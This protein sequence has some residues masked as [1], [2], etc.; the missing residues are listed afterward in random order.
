[1]CAS[2]VCSYALVDRLSYLDW[3]LRTEDEVVGKRAASLAS[4]NSDSFGGCIVHDGAIWGEAAHGAGNT[5]PKTARTS[6]GYGEATCATVEKLL[7][8]LSRLTYYV[9]A[10]GGW[11]GLWNLDQDAS[12]L[13]VGSGYGKVVFHAKLMCGV[14]CSVGIECV[15]KRTELADLAK[16]GLYAELDRA[17]L[18]DDLLKGVSFEAADATA[19]ARLDYS[20]VYVFDR[21]FSR[22]TLIAL[23]KVLQRSSF[24]VMISSHKPRVWWECG[25][26]KIQ[27]VAKTRCVTT[28]RERMTFFI[29]INSHFIPCLGT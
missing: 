1:V 21:V 8:L 6:E 9:P 25:L 5:G 14:R 4:Q 26:T 12:F 3:G 2:R 19:Y 23:A 22:V 15:A 7:R 29:Y 16:H 24:Y 20:H 18:A 28:G 11:A 17:K 13:D 27:P 10:M